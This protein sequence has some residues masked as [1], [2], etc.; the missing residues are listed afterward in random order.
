MFQS[1]SVPHRCKETYNHAVKHAE[2]CAAPLLAVGRGQK[3]CYPTA[4]TDHREANDLE[5]HHLWMF[6]DVPGCSTMF[7]KRYVAKT[8]SC[9]AVGPI[10]DLWQLQSRHRPKSHIRERTKM[11]RCG[12]LFQRAEPDTH[13]FSSRNGRRLTEPL[14][15]LQDLGL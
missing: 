14:L 6:H 3:W 5:V 4:R 12:K 9:H 13:A 10:H 7:R 8:T 2:A 15:F 1:I 11:A